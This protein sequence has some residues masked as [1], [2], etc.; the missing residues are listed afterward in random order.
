[1][2]PAH[3]SLKTEEVVLQSLTQLH[4]YNHHG[5]Y[6]KHLLSHAPTH[7]QTHTHTH[8]QTHR[9]Q[10]QTVLFSVSSDSEHLFKLCS[11]LYNG[12]FSENSETSDG[13]V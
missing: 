11:A 6:L 8:V 12:L 7:K 9:K 5:I 4:C 13:T 10:Q 3:S 1:M 2:L